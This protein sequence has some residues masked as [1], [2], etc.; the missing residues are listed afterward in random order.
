M[1]KPTTWIFLRQVMDNL[2]EE[3][4]RKN[5]RNIRS[6]GTTPEL[7][8]MREL[9]RKNIY[10]AKHVDKIIG[11]PDIVF[12]RKKVVVFIDS[13]F[14]HGH[15]ERFIMPKTNTEYWEKKIARNKE[16]DLEVSQRLREQGWT[17]IR[18][19]EYEIK[20]YLEQCMQTILE[21]IGQLDDELGASSRRACPK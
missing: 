18:I 1:K 2:T 14:W 7:M 5:M 8:V 10:F 11:K 21:A 4:R 9:R 19:W 3:Q 20:H 12:R 16:R 17:V 6:K 15:P 13:D